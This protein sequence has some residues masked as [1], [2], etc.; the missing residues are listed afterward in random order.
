MNPEMNKVL[1]VDDEPSMLE[2]ME[3]VLQKENCSVTTT[4]DPVEALGMVE[5]QDFD[6]VVQDLKMPKMNGLKLLE[7]I[8]TLRPELPVIIITAFS[9]WDNT[10]F[11]SISRI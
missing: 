6:A 1:V 9:T 3:I 10:L 5:E 7:K 11:R 8:K 4:P 2:M